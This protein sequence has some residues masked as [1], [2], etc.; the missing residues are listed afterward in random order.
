MRLDSR[1]RQGQGAAPAGWIPEAPPPSSPGSPEDRPLGG[2]SVPG[3]G[4]PE[5]QR[6]Q[7]PTLAR[8]CHVTPALPLPVAAASVSGLRGT[9]P[10]RA[11]RDVQGRRR[12]CRWKGCSFVFGIKLRRRCPLG[13]RDE[14]P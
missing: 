5:L 13:R 11:D 3:A 12:R 6:H 9:R 7:H 10:G 1:G 8:D 14:P 4:S 2:G